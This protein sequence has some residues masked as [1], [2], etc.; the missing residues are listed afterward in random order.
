MELRID[1][2]RVGLHEILT[3][4]VVALGLDSLDLGEKLGEQTAESLVVIHH[5]VS[6]SVTH[7]LLD[8]SA[9][10]ALLVAPLGDQLAVL[11]MRLS[12]LLAELDTCELH[13]QTIPDVV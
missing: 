9:C 13:E 7:L 2:D 3:G 8:D 11:H 12:V 5:E 1:V 4:C 10:G 6:L